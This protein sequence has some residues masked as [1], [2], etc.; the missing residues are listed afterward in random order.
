MLNT[1]CDM[2]GDQHR[3]GRLQFGEPM[4]R[5]STWRAGGPAERYYEPA[6][7][8]DLVEFIAALPADESLTWVG[9]GSNLLVRDGGIAGTVVMT[10]GALNK[11]EP[12]ARGSFRIEAGVACARVA[13]ETA[14]GGYTGAEFLAGIPGTMGGALVMNAGAY[15]QETWQIVNLV[16]TLDRTGHL[17]QRTVEEFEI[18]YRSV[19]SSADEWF[20]AAHLVLQRGEPAE[21]L[22]RIRAFME[23][24]AATQPVG[25]PTCG[26]VFRNPPGDHAARLIEAAGLKGFR[27]GGC[28]VSEK[29]ANFIVNEHAATAKDIESL[30]QHIQKAVREKF[31]VQL[32]PEVK[33]IGRFSA[34]QNQAGDGDA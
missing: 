31:G 5:H 20:V 21:C 12:L 24:R 9:L 27:Q 17:H 14:S 32:E 28:L 19:R 34:L 3:R 7:L 6:D 26:S 13:R 1:G 11:I 23:H 15:E 33:I 25:K 22:S 10:A 16:E 8:D 4:A 2:Q 30:I 18:G 29:H